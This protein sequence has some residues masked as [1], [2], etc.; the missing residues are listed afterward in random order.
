MVDRPVILRAQG[1]LAR[2]GALV[3]DPPTTMNP[4]QERAP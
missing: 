3:S 1:V 4:R 2:A